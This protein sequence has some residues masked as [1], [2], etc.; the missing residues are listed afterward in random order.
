MKHRSAL[1]AV[2]PLVRQRLLSHFAYLEGKHDNATPNRITHL[3]KM[4]F[5]PSPANLDINGPPQITKGRPVLSIMGA[6]KAHLQP[7]A[8]AC[9]ALAVQNKPKRLVEVSFDADSHGLSMIQR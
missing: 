4:T 7:G 1:D 9:T 2:S 6:V 3:E 8:K 5:I